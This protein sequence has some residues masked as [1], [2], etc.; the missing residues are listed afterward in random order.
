MGVGGI[1][2]LRDA[3]Q[4]EIQPGDAGGALHLGLAQAHRLGTAQAFQVE[5]GKG[6]A[7]GRQMRQQLHAMPL[8]LHPHT[9]PLVLQLQQGPFQLTLADQ[10]PGADEVEEHLDLQYG[11]HAWASSAASTAF[12]STPS[13]FSR[14]MSAR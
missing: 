1:G 10:A 13:P 3:A 9:G 8:L 12:S 7:L 2:H 4:V 5:G 6:H 11:A 14:A